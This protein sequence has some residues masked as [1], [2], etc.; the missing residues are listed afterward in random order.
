M[1]IHTHKFYI[2][3]YIYLYISTGDSYAGLW[4]Q[5]P[6]AGLR[7]PEF[8]HGG[9]RTCGGQYLKSLCEVG[10]WSELRG[11]FLKDPGRFDGYVIGL[12]LLGKLEPESPINLMVKTHGFPVDFPVKTN[13]MNME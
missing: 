2:Y 1:Y 4:F 3:I 8:K 11:L 13:P 10:N 7:L 6:L 12:V 5:S 9:C